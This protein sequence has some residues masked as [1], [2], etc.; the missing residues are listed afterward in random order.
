[1]ELVPKDTSLFSNLERKVH[2]ELQPHDLRFPLLSLHQYL[3]FPSLT[4][5]RSEILHLLTTDD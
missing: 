2:R 4:V 5:S 1:M 3:Y